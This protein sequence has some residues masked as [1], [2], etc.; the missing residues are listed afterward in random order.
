MILD[1]LARRRADLGQSEDDC[2]RYAAWR[3]AALQYWCSI[4]YRNGA[5]TE[6]YP[7]EE[8]FPATAF[9]TYAACLVVQAMDQPGPAVRSAIE[10]ACTWLLRHPEPRASNQQAAALAAVAMAAKIE[11]IHVN[12]QRLSDQITELL[13]R[14]STEGWFPE[15]D[16]PDIGYLSVALD[17]L[18]DLQTATGRADVADAMTRTVEFLAQCTS[19][20]GSTPPMLGSRNTD[21]VT[22]YGL[23]RAARH[24]ALAGAVC[25]KLF[26]GVDSPLHPL[27]AT[28]DRYAVHYIR[29]SCFR[30]LEWLRDL[31]EAPPPLPCE[32]GS[33]E[34]LADAGILISHEPDRRSVFVAGRKGGVVYLFAP[35]GR[36]TADYGWRRNLGRGR[37]AVTHWQDPANRVEGPSDGKIG[38][39]VTGKVSTLRFLVPTPVRHFVLRVLSFFLRH[40]LRPLL[41]GFLILN[42]TDTGVGF[43]RQVRIEDDDVVIEDSFDG[44][45]PTELQRAPCYSLR[46]V[47]SAGQCTLDDATVPETTALKRRLRLDQT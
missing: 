25:R 24:N 19:V 46:W 34:F 6:F 33:T 43:C 10:R 37:V 22:P 7:W 16:G 9:S 32:Q 18:A 26:L 36:Q 13:S 4:Q 5:F 31:P 11:G 38:L 1:C 47:P 23:V 35:D 2:R 17:A 29:Q 12:D 39:T 30:A 14:Q 42:R 44:V 21:Y 45:S 20:S 40:R 41:K 27:N 15:Y 8:S 3:T 28:D